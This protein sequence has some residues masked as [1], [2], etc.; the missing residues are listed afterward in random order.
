MA[1]E[2]TNERARRW[3]GWLPHA[4]VAIGALLVLMWAALFANLVSDGWLTAHLGIWP[5]HARGLIG[6]PFAPFLHTGIAH[7]ATSSL[8]FAMLSAIT[9]FRHG[10]R[11]FA[12]VSLS[13]VLLGGLGVWLVGRNVAHVGASG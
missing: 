6:V 4:A 5:R 1:E 11:E 10:L 13:I 9:I 3:E 2:R 7:T 12:L 8:A